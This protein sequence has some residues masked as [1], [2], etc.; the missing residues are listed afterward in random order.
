MPIE[1]SSS[2]SALSRY[3]KSGGN[4]R[5]RSTP[6]NIDKKL[7]NAPRF[8]AQ[9]AENQPGPGSHDIALEFVR[10]DF[11]KALKWTREDRQRYLGNPGTIRKLNEND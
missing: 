10:K 7:V 8:R 4:F 1:A 5:P 3:S 11:G 9:T 2:A 6:S